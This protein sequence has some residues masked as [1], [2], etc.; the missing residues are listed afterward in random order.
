[1]LHRNLLGADGLSKERLACRYHR[2]E[3][4]LEFHRS[5]LCNN[6]TG[7]GM[8]C[9]CPQEELSSNETPS[10]ARPLGTQA[11]ATANTPR[12]RCPF[13]GDAHPPAGKAASPRK[14]R[15][16]PSGSL[17]PG[18][19]ARER[20]SAPSP[21]T[22]VEFYREPLPPPRPEGGGEAA[23]GRL[24]VQA[25]RQTLGPVRDVQFSDHL[26]RTMPGTCKQQVLNTCL[27]SGIEGPCAVG[28][29]FS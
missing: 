26:L 20:H 19:E 16:G 15:R 22:Q 14:R 21:R 17:E 2:I 5:V 11:D 10:S 25:C 24:G 12:P 7:A 13:R 23:E 4:Q 18:E 29:C 1:M 28:M 9:G 8:T 3:W 6:H 27:L